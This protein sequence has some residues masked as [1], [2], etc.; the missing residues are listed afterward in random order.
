MVVGLYRGVFTADHSLL[1]FVITCPR[2]DLVLRDKDKLFVFGNPDVIKGAVKNSFNL[3]MRTSSDGKACLTEKE[4]APPVA[5]KEVD[6]KKNLSPKLITK[7]A[8]AAIAKAMDLSQNGSVPV[9]ESTSNANPL[10]SVSAVTTS[11]PKEQTKKK[12][13]PAR[14]GGAL[15]LPTVRVKASVAYMN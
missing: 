7:T 4:R 10:T 3:P 12:R 9:M 14:R 5:K 11:V 15:A 13:R 2:P 6:E 8:R 1:P